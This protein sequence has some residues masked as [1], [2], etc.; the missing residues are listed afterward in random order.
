MYRTASV[1]KV[2]GWRAAVAAGDAAAG[3]RLAPPLTRDQS[4]VTQGAPLG[5]SPSAIRIKAN[6]LMLF[7]SHLITADFVYQDLAPTLS[8]IVF[9]FPVAAAPSYHLISLIFFPEVVFASGVA[10]FGI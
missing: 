5:Y 10:R 3:R 6:S 9:L 2:R 7:P 8:P 1:R 4:D